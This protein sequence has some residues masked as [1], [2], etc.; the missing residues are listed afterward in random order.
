[1]NAAQ[2]CA[3]YAIEGKTGRIYF[4]SSTVNKFIRIYTNLSPDDF[5]TEMKKRLKIGVM[6]DL[7]NEGIGKYYNAAKDLPPDKIELPDFVLG[8]TK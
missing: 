8:I 5:T 7:H 3:E 2:F 4:S 1:M 6:I